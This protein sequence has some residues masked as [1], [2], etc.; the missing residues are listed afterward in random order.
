MSRY[1][2]FALLLC[3]LPSSASAQDVTGH[4][5]AAVG[6]AYAL[7]GYEGYAF[8]PDVRVGADLTFGEERSHHAVLELGWTGFAL[9]GAR[10]DVVVTSCGWRW[11][12]APEVGFYVAVAAG[13]GLALDSFDAQLGARRLSGVTARPALQG[14]L[15]VGIT[16]LEHL[17]VELVYRQALLGGEVVDALGTIG[18]RVGGRL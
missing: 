9:P 16:V 3:G 4:P 7:I 18:A 8:A 10:L 12:P 13:G 11:V 2:L 15:G 14:A 1:L 17:D 5:T 6:F